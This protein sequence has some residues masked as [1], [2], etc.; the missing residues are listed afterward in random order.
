MHGDIFKFVKK[1]YQLTSFVKIQ[2]TKD[3]CTIKHLDWSDQKGSTPNNQTSYK[4]LAKI[5][6]STTK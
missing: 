2:I 1:I 6:V 4:L 3:S 5:E